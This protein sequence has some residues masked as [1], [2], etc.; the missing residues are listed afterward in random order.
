MKGKDYWKVTYG[1][2]KKKEV[3]YIEASYEW[4][5]EEKI[6]KIY[7]ELNPEYKIVRVEKIAELQFK[8][9]EDSNDETCS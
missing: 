3:Q 5:D 1:K 4:Y 2:D 7:N 9:S 8:K 6:K